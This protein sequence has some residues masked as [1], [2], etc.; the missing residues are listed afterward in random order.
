MD[1][2][3]S[4]GIDLTRRIK[5]WFLDNTDG[6]G[7][8]YVAQIE[9]LPGDDHVQLMEAYRQLFEESPRIKLDYGIDAMR[10]ALEHG[11]ML[12]YLRLCADTLDFCHADEDGYRHLPMIMSHGKEQNFYLSSSITA[13]TANPTPMMIVC[14]R[15]RKS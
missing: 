3:M 10:F 13:I 9:H 15:M 5:V 8:R 4:T 6:Q 11:V 12:H 1:S 14:W 2:N 7:S